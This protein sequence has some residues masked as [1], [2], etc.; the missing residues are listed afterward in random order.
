MIATGG[1]AGASGRDAAIPLTGRLGPAPDQRIDER[2][3]GGRVCH[4]ST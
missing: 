4:H 3:S 1:D 2:S